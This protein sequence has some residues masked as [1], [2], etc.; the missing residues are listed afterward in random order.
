M[1]GN[2]YQASDDR[3][4]PTVVYALYLLG[5]INGLTV[6]VGLIIAYANRGRA[7]FVADSHYTFQIRTFWIGLIV[8]FVGGVSMMW[9]AIWGAIPFIGLVGIPFVMLGL[10]LF[11]LTHLWFAVRCIVGLVYVSRGEAHPRPL[12]WLA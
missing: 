11:L 2:D 6:I 7:G 4:L 1:S 8:W 9:G 12:A 10:T 3:T 5:L